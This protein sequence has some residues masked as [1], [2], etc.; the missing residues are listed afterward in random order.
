MVRFGDKQYEDYTM[1]RDPARKR[2][3]ISRHKTRENWHKNG[4]ATAGF[5]SR[6]ILWNKP[7]LASSIRDTEQRFGIKIDFQG[8]RVR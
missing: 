1:H 8:A 4:I 2:Q 3:Y 5:W 6:W 7:T